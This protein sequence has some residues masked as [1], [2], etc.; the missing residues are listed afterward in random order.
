MNRFINRSLTSRMANMCVSI[1][2]SSGTGTEIVSTSRQLPGNLQLADESI[3][4][5]LPEPLIPEVDYYFPRHPSL[6]P[7]ST[8]VTLWGQPNVFSPEELPLSRQVFGVAYRSDIINN[9]VKYLRHKR[10]QPKK[11]KRMSEISGS[12]KKP[13]PQKRQGKA[14]AGNK[15]NSVWRHGQ[16]AHGPKLRDYS[17]DMPKKIRALGMMIVLAA[18]LREGNLLVVDSFALES[19]R[20]KDFVE[21]AA[22]HGLGAEKNTLF[23]DTWAELESPDSRLNMAARNVSW[24]L[25]LP[26]EKLDVYNMMQKPRLVITRSALGQLQDRVLAQYFNTGRVVKYG[27]MLDH[28]RD[29]VT[30]GEKQQQQQD[31]PAIGEE[32]Y[33]L[34]Q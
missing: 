19:H 28:Y 10:R 26:Q 8:Q 17:I 32:K 23:A 34:A 4:D 22:L 11:T 33:A 21:T 12:G 9:V 13:H 3:L 6:I 31:Q 7:T 15:R 20:T 27:R 14:Q 24:A 1:R 16:K 18:K 30:D 25:A 5:E 2:R 29:L